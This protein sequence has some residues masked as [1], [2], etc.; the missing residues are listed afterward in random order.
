MRALA[1]RGNIADAL[2]VYERLSDTL[3]EELGVSP[4]PPTQDLHLSLLRLR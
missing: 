3:R 2:R 4:S 1:E